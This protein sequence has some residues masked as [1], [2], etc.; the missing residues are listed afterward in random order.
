MVYAIEDLEDLS[1]M[2]P[3]TGKALETARNLAAQQPTPEKYRQV[4]LN[5]LAVWAVNDYLELMGIP[6]DITA[7]DCWNPVV[8]LAADVADLVVTGLGKIE[9]RPMLPSEENI[10]SVGSDVWDDRLAYVVVRVD[11]GEN[12]ARV[13]GFSTQTEG[14]ADSGLPIDDLQ[15]IEDLLDLVWR[16]ETG[17][18]VVE[19]FL[20]SSDESV[21]AKVREQLARDGLASIVAKLERIYRTREEYNWRFDAVEVLGGGKTESELALKSSDLVASREG[22]DEDDEDDELLDFAENLM[23]ELAEVWQDEE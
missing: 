20:E 14:F 10:C 19:N 2:M 23:D 13:L 4:Y 11:E 7:G 12:E 16:L 21:E 9:C 3:L 1:L 5:A 22:D 15:A 8:S 17:R 6:T 18:D